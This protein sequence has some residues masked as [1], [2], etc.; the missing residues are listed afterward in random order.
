[1]LPATPVQVSS[2]GWIEPDHLPCRILT[3][4]VGSGVAPSPLGSSPALMR[5]VM[6]WARRGRTYGKQALVWQ[7]RRCLAWNHSPAPPSRPGKRPLPKAS[8]HEMNQP[9]TGWLPGHGSDVTLTSALLSQDRSVATPPH[10]R[11]G[12][13]S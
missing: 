9:S 10:P 2:R 5:T 4:G 3:L 6:G 11:E 1:M 8:L 13:G 12:A 7:G